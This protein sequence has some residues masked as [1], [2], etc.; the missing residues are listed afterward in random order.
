M[1]TRIVITAQYCYVELKSSLK[2][3]KNVVCFKSLNICGDQT[4]RAL[5][6]ESRTTYKGVAL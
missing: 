4:L 2:Q 5:T 3:R 1:K 6:L